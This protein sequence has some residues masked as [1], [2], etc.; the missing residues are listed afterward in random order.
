VSD[1]A[2]DNKVGAAGEQ[3]HH[4]ASSENPDGNFYRHVNSFRVVN[5][6]DWSRIK[7]CCYRSLIVDAVRQRV[8]GAFD[9]ASIN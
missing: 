5:T 4:P 7:G 3:R 9:L 8:D 6:D 1:K 2:V